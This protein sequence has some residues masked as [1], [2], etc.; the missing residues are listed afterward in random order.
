MLHVK[1]IQGFTQNDIYKIPKKEKGKENLKSLHNT[2]NVDCYKYIYFR[3]QEK[4]ISVSMVFFCF[5]TPN[6]FIYICQIHKYVV[7]L[8]FTCAMR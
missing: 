4:I 7:Y 8:C 5:C 3:F 2:R 1:Y 6:F